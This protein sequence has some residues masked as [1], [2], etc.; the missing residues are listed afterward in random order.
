M[1]DKNK[2]HSSRIIELESQLEM[3]KNQLEKAKRNLASTEKD[4]ND[5]RNKEKELK[6]ALKAKD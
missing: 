6:Q 4:L 2:Q 5:S 3:T 1:E